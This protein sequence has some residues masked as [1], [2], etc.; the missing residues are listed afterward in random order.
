[1]SLVSLLLS[2]PLVAQDGAAVRAALERG[3]F[4]AA[5]SAMEAQG[6]ALEKQRERS[7]ILYA[8]GDPAGAL[9]AAEQ[10][11]ALAPT[12]LELLHRATSSA[13]WLSEPE[14]ARAFA[15]RLAAA[16]DQVELAPEYRQGWR[17]SRDDFL[18]RVA[19]LERHEAARAGAIARARAGAWVA[20]GAVLVALAL[21]VRGQGRSSSPVS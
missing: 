9:A 7:Q 5:W 19:E 12:E 13:L 3:D 10:G 4:L 11:L 8:A 16:V 20:L 6:D 17:A 21:G 14:R 1:V 15:T 18:E 2:V